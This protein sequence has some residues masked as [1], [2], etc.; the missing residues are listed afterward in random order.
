[1]Q[2]AG[3]RVVHISGTDH[4][5]VMTT[6]YLPKSYLLD[7]YTVLYKPLEVTHIVSDGTLC[8]ELR[9][10]LVRLLVPQKLQV[11]SLVDSLFWTC[12]RSVCT[13]MSVHATSC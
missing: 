9:G 1:M 8:S 10:R 5:S 12:N 7:V 6:L 3:V 11:P 4:Q 13:G 2:A